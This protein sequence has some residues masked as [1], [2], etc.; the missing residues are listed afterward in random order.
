MKITK[1]QIRKFCAKLQ[2][3]EDDIQDIASRCSSEEGETEL[4]EALWKH[5]V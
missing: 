5:I 4:A 1:K 2:I 3:L